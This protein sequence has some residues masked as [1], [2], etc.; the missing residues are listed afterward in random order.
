MLW[1]LLLIPAFLFQRILLCAS[2]SALA[3]S[4]RHLESDFFE[5]SLVMIVALI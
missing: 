1:Y 3:T 2:C 4:L 5:V